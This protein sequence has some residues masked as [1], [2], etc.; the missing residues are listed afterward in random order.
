M[1][2]TNKVLII[3]TNSPRIYSTTG[4]KRIIL[5]C[6]KCDKCKMM[7]ESD[8]KTVNDILCKIHNNKMIEFVEK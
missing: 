7:F 6:E 2:F 1:N 5:Y 8:A 4:H 3:T